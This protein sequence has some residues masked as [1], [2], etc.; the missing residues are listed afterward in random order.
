MG[1]YKFENLIN[2][3]A[4]FHGFR[5]NYSASCNNHGIDLTSMGKGIGPLL[6]A[7]D[8][9]QSGYCLRLQNRHLEKIGKSVLPE[10]HPPES[11][12]F[13]IPSFHNTGKGVGNMR[14]TTA[15]LAV[16]L[17]PKHGR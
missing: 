2:W 13:P 8:A 16:R 7:R 1:P 9:G 14:L 15:Q 6:T 5:T 3:A 4:V 11:H 10:A 17:G 12:W